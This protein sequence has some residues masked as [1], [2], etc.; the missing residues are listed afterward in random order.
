[1]KTQKYDVNDDGRLD[2]DEVR[3]MLGAL[4]LDGVGDAEARAAVAAMDA[5][6]DGFVSF[7]EFTAFYAKR[8]GF[9]P[10]A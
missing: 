1:M 10:A 4:G 2:L 6:A 5:D 7:A 8:K 3:R 9:T